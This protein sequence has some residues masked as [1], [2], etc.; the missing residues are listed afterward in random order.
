VPVTGLI[1]R[2]LAEQPTATKRALQERQLFALP[3]HR[4]ET[5]RDVT[6]ARTTGS[7]WAGA[8]IREVQSHGEPRWHW[9]H[10]HA[11]V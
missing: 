8:R 11:R 5:E 10:T 3:R 1:E 9:V 4:V 7:L 2:E 6:S